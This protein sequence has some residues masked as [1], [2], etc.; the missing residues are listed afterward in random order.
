MSF[1]RDIVNLSKLVSSLFRE[2][3]LN[4][5][6]LPL[7]FNEEKQKFLK[8]K[9][10]NPQFLYDKEAI[11]IKIKDSDLDS[12]KIL[13]KKIRTNK[14]WY[15]YF[16]IYLEDCFDVIK[17]NNSIG[18]NDEFPE[19]SKK[20][21]DKLLINLPKKLEINEELDEAEMKYESYEYLYGKFL[22]YIDHYDLP[23][24]I[25]ISNLNLNN[26]RITYKQIIM[27]KMLKRTKEDCDRLVV[28]EI[29]SHL[30]QAHNGINLDILK[31]LN[32]STTFRQKLFSEGLAVYNEYKT[33][34]ETQLSEIIY[35]LRLKAVM[36]SDLSFSSLFKYVNTFLPT[37]LAINITF[38]VKRGM[39]DT[40]L[41]GGYFKDSLYYLGYR[42]IKNLIDDGKIPHEYFYLGKVTD[43]EYN[44]LKDQLSNAKD[45]LV[46]PSFIEN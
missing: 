1:D 8:D 25:N 42:E 35:K 14:R 10:Y 26:L 44:L 11:R 41:P 24:Q 37:N 7:N 39:S 3:S 31:H 18:D 32:S 34:N 15:D 22:K 12:I 46:L 38:R 21:F 36:R 45:M 2:N 20:I 5:N 43:M 33:S 16:S 40:S 13:L 28:H 6:L 30:L 19:I 29:E 23:T 9:E 4:K 27:N 17:L